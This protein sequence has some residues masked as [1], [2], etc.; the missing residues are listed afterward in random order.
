MLYDIPDTH[1]DDKL[2]KGKPTQYGVVKGNYETTDRNLYMTLQRELME[3][4]GVEFSIDMIGI[5][6]TS[7]VYNKV[8]YYIPLSAANIMAFRDAIRVKNQASYGEL[9][10]LQFMKLD[11]L[12]HEQMN[13]IAKH[14]VKHLPTLA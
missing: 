8:V 3:E 12:K 7:E 9:Y 5:A 10:A 1:E 13:A 6:P 14:V 11:T 4:L 2:K